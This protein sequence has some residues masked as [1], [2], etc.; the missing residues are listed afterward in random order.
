MDIHNKLTENEKKELDSLL[1]NVL[2]KSKQMNRTL[3]TNTRRLRGHLIYLPQENDKLRK[4]L[5]K[6]LK[7]KH[8]LNFLI[9]KRYHSRT[10][11]KKH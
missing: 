5:L 11:G 10:Y 6:S 4:I 1:I 3:K 9:F 7:I 8:Y 2:R